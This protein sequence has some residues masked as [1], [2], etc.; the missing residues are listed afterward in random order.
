MIVKAIEFE[1]LEEACKHKDKYDEC[2]EDD[3]YSGKCSC[4]EC[5]IWNE[6]E[7][8]AVDL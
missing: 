7:S 5:P 1:T 8:S 3:N 6:L 4:T 2:T